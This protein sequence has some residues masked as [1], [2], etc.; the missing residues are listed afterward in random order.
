MKTF[1]LGISSIIIVC[2]IAGLILEGTRF[3][4]TASKTL[5]VIVV[6]SLCVA[7]LSLFFDVKNTTFNFDLDINENYVNEIN[8]IKLNEIKV[9]IVEEMENIGIKN[10]EVY[11]STS[12]LDGE[13]KIEKVHLDVS[14]AEY[15][16]S[17]TNINTIKEH[18]KKI[19]NVSEENVIVYL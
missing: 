4:K 17:T 10:S 8:S 11:F 19:I 2:F 16:S 1:I 7:V 14:N 3:E 18:V 9:E 6:T 12:Y 13:L 15:N 5:S